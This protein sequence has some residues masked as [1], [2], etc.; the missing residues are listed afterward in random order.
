MYLKFVIKLL[1]LRIK[2]KKEKE[3]GCGNIWIYIRVNDDIF[4]ILRK[5][6][7]RFCEIFDFIKRRWQ[8]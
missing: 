7:D 1:F 3:M 4:L 6:M 2:K 5:L 8:T